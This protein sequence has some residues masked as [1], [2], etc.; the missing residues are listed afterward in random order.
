ML[1]VRVPSEHIHR[2]LCGMSDQNAAKELALVVQEG[3]RLIVEEQ[4]RVALSVDSETWGE[5]AA[6]IQRAER[7][8]VIGA[9]RSRLAISMVAMRL[10]HLGLRVHVIGEVTTPAIQGGDLL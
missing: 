6:R 2:G 4:R 8:F 1:N 9:G 5:A 7:I 10:M 3:I